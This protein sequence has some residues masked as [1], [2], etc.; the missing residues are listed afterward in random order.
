M[1]A[2]WRTALKIVIVGAGDVGYTIARNLSGEGHD[3]VVIEHK[4]DQAKKVEN[5]LDV[6]VV[7]GN[8]SRPAV[9][10]E[11]GI[12]AGCNIDYLIACSNRDEVN[13]MACWQAKRC[14]VKRVISRAK[15]IE[16]E[17]NPQWSQALGIDEI[18]TPERSVARDIEEMLWINAAVHTSE[19]MKGKAGSYAFRITPDSPLSGKSLKEIGSISRGLPF[20]IIFVERE[21][22]GQI[23]SGD[24]VLQNDDLC[25]VITFKQHVLDIQ[26][27]FLVEKKRKQM[28]RLIIVGGGKL[29]I[30]L[31]RLLVKNHPEVN[32][33]LIDLDH[34]RCSRLA[35]EFPTL[36]VLHG[37]G[38]DEKL[39][40][41]E[42]ID[43]TDGFLAAT[44]N[45]E[46][47]MV[48]A[49]LAKSL[50]SGKCIALIRKEVYTQLASQLPID[51]LVNPNESLS[52]VI[53]R[54]VRYPETAG[55]LS[56]IG[57]IGAEILESTLP[58]ASPA[59]GKK[60]ADLHLPK[61]VLF[62]MVNRD[63]ESL[64]PQGSLVLKGGDVLLIFAMDEKM[65]KA[66]KVLGMIR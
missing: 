28:R 3:I 9:L 46:L 32:I 47:N 64:M 29:G 36:T 22:I 48:L 14:G 12:A 63:G 34:D 40:R 59:V 60:I 17:D 31:V 51:A 43:L 24:W 52:S 61:G 25:Y 6:R 23:P 54:F 49:I 4:A 5:E 10:E 7:I 44:D 38:T 20:V 45:E 15:G 65:S 37:D 2:K 1:A 13:I 39:L 30:Q 16:Y 62:A 33:K 26:K 56:M 53:L 55:S 58:D 57:R 18:I 27:L 21:G 41:H 50:G 35:S 66:L 11:A 8:G 19:L 42:G